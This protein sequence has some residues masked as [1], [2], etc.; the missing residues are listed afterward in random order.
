MKKDDKF[1]LFAVF[2]AALGVGVFLMPKLQKKCSNKLYKS[3]NRKIL[4]DKY[5]ITIDKK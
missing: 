2:S 5:G 1:I 4:R 3:Y